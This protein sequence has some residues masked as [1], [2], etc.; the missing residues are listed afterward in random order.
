[1]NN[2]VT[3]FFVSFLLILLVIELKDI[4]QSEI[5]KN[6]KIEQKSQ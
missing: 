5:D 3:Y 4:K 1:M 2:I 6:T